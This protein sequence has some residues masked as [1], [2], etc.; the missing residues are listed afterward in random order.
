MKP[1]FNQLINKLLFMKKIIFLLL[2]SLIGWQHAQAQSFSMYGLNYTIT[3]P[4][5]VSITGAVND[6]FSYHNSLEIPQSVE[7]GNLLSDYNCY[8]DEAIQE[9]ICNWDYYY[10]QGGNG[11]NYAVTSIGNE[12]FFGKNFST[13]IIPNSVT[14]IGDFAFSNN[15]NLQQINLPESITYIGYGAFTSCFSATSLIIPSTVTTINSDAFYG[16]NTLT[17]VTC[18][19]TTPINISS[20]VFGT[21]NQ[22]ACSLTVPDNSFSAYQGASVWQNFS[23]INNYYGPITPASSLNFSAS[24]NTVNLGS[25]LGNFGTGDFAIE[26]KV[27]TN[28]SSGRMYLVDKRSFCDR[29]NLLDVS[30][31]PEGYVVLETFNFWVSNNYIT[32]TISITDNTWHQ[33][34]VTRTA[35]Y[36]KIYVDG[37]LDTTSET[38][39][40]VDLNNNYNLV[41]GGNTACKP[42]GTE[43]FTGNMDEVRFWNRS[44]TQTE[45]QT[46]MNC[47]IQTTGNGLLANYHFNQG[48]SNDNNGAVASLVDSSGNNNDGALENFNLTGAHSNWSS[49]AAVPSGVACSNPVQ[50]TAIPDANFEQALVDLGIDT[51]NGDHRVLTSAVSGLTSLDVSSKSISDL[52]GIEDFT[53]LQSLN[54]YYNNLTSLPISNLTG[55]QNL[56]CFTN[57]LTSLNVSGLVA[58]Q[59]I[60]CSQNQLTQL[61]LSGLPQLQY[62]FCQYNQLDSINLSGDQNLMYLNVAY[63]QF[64]QLD[65]SG[66]TNLST[67]QCSYNHLSSLDLSGLHISS[68]DCN[69]NQMTSLNVT[70]LTSLETLNCFNNHLNR[71]NLSSLSNLLTMR[72]Y[73]NPTLSCITVANPNAANTDANWTKDPIAFYSTNC[74]ITAPPTASSQVLCAGSTIAQLVAT[75]ANLQWYAAQTGGAALANAELLASGSYFVSQTLNGIESTRTEV[76]V[77]INATPALASQSY[78]VN[79]GVALSSVPG[80]GDGYKVYA[81]ADAIAAFSSS[82]VLTN[83]TYYATQIQNGCESTRSM[84]TVVVYSLTSVSSPAC[85]SRLNAITA[86]I[87]ATAVANATNYLFEVTGNGSTRTLY[88]L[89]N[90]F[91]LTQLQGTNGYNTTYSIRVAAGFNG[92]YGDFGAA[93]SLTTPALANTTQV[94]STLCGTTLASLT[95]P[96][97]C[98]QIVG[99]QAY[100]FE[101][102]TGGVSKTIDSATNSVQIS[103]LTGGPAYGTAYSVRVAAQVS[104]TWQTYGATCTVTTPAASSQ[105]RTNQCGTTLT[106]KWA[107]LYCSAVTGATGYRFEWSNGGTVLTYSSTTSN[108]QLGNYTGWAINTTYSVRVAVQF[109]GTWQA[110]GSACNVKSPATFA[111]QNAEETVSLT[112]KAIPNPFE[113]EY[114]LMAQGGN[115]TPVQ[116]AVYDM[117]GKQVEQFSI[118]ASELE[119][120]SLGTNYSSGIY[121]VMISQGDEQQVVRIIKK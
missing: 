64:T 104:N 101:F 91:N 38:D 73:N 34:T 119:N 85:G 33:I 1:T 66:F 61:D 63:N 15:Y 18:N 114:V 60:N 20:N 120:R 13:L 96:I 98:G 57:Q 21:L 118:E 116:V 80:Y 4:S 59:N 54:C 14:T 81:T 106:G 109:G 83:G 36:L 110:Y 112:V 46:N 40:A 77:T 48:N 45:I 9:E 30:I 22:S 35:G 58:L 69:D 24:S 79:G 5:T 44:L 93:C 39:T 6:Y 103:N 31:T 76:P 51:V 3:S 29:D 99:A 55:L 16:C 72:C 8:Y 95:T 7:F 42:Y 26:M 84:V 86:P 92:Q 115:Q 67:L 27:K 53:S 108:M 17:S 100:R 50:Y 65:V 105:I 25:T 70:G 89:T 10:D 107:I 121:N 97:Y 87:T 56:A 37:V 49:E 111:R 11:Q 68:L 2:F 74:N 43:Y 12:A 88:S 32:G 23:P 94:I 75:G 102:T 78:F 90:S 71:L 47:E 19:A 117:L 62:A 82:T 41:L 52:T 113:T 28:P